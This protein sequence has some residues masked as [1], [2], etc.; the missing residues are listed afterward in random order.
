[1]LQ[2]CQ[3]LLKGHGR[4]TEC[5]DPSCLQSQMICIC[6]PPRGFLCLLAQDIRMVFRN[7][8]RVV[9]LTRGILLPCQLCEHLYRILFC[10]NGPLDHRYRDS[11]T[12]PTAL[13][14]SATLITIIMHACDE[15]HQTFTKNIRT[16]RA[17]CS[18]SLS[19]KLQRCI[20]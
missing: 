14:A 20:Q 6:L 8:R 12:R 17:G 3:L 13:I 10:Y 5:E 4:R 16:G 9:M 18:I 1:M 2:L 11:E 15:R 7:S 19:P